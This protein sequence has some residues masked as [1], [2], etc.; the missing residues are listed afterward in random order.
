MSI[1]VDACSPVIGPSTA[2]NPGVEDRFE[3]AASAIGV[4][5]STAISTAAIPQ[6]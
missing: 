3:R 2:T 6:R 1:P 5:M 4:P